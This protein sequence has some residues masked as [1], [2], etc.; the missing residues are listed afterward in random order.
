MLEKNKKEIIKKHLDKYIPS[1]VRT[2]RS[3][4]DKDVFK[5]IEINI[6]SFDI[7]ENVQSAINGKACFQ[8]NYEKVKADKGAFFTFVPEEFIANVSDVLM[9][10]E[11][12][13]EYKGSLSELEINAIINL[14]QKLNQELMTLSNKINEYEVIYEDK[15]IYL[16]KSTVNIEE[17]TKNN[18]CDFLINT[19]LKINS[20]K[21]YNLSILTSYEALNHSLT[22]LGLFKW[23]PPKKKRELEEVNINVISDL[24]INLNAVLG[25]AEIP[26]KRALELTTGSLIELES[27]PDSD[28]KIFVRGIEVAQ[29]Q[30]VVVG[31]NFGL[32]ITKIISPEERLRYSK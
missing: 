16:D 22:K 5:K 20:D 4:L 9:G 15:P 3:M 13:V 12:N 6:A 11:G 24:E 2:M 29:A 19:I 27:T 7:V 31:D 8:Q 17:I 23:E 10:G 21:E 14:L 18:N 28:V 26:M 30:I 1:S 25:R 32:R